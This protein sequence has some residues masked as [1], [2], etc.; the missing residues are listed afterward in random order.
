MGTSF[1][2]RSNNVSIEHGKILAFYVECISYDL[3]LCLGEMEV[4][5]RTSIV[6]S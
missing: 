5:Q 6:L 4:H 2:S 1:F 3:R